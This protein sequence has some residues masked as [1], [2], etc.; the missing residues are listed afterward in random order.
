VKAKVENEAV[1]PK[2]V[3]NLFNQP[4]YAVFDVTTIE[5]QA[6]QLLF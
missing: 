1:N 2:K 4:A 6:S 3:S 5:A